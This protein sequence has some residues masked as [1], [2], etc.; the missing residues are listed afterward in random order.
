MATDGKTMRL[1]K[2]IRDDRGASMVEF[3]IIVSLF[4]VVLFG[5]IEFSLALYQWNSATKAVQLGARL[6][7]V[8][9]PVWNQLSDMSLV[10]GTET[11][12]DPVPAYTVECVGSTSACTCIAGARCSGTNTYNNAAMNVLV[13][14]RDANV[15]CG[16]VGAGGFLGMCDVYNPITP[17][18]VKVTYENSGLGFLGHPAGTVPTITVEVT[19]M[20]YQFI[21]LGGLMGFGITSMPDFK[22]TMTGEDLNLAAP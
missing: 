20:S 2:I 21:F 14:G 12:G 7:A 1:Q 5:L 13:Y 8:S 9:S 6:A 3:S 18:N 4:F 15:A 22:V 17:A 19:G 10:G 16:N 11:L